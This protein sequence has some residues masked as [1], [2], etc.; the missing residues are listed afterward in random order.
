MIE[1]FNMT[2]PVLHYYLI[3]YQIWGSSLLFGAFFLRF[4]SFPPFPG[5]K[6]VSFVITFPFLNLASL[7]FLPCLPYLIPAQFS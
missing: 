4:P 6:D 1:S 2:G 3:C 7:T 5:L